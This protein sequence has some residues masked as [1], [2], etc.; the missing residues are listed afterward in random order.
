MA[1]LV[2][3]TAIVVGTTGLVFVGPSGAG[4][5]AMALRT[6]S[7]A[8][9]SG[10]FAALVSDD[11]VFLAPASGRLIATA[12]ETI[13]TM[14]ELRGS[15]IGHVETIDSV[16]LSFAIEPV[17]VDAHNRIPQENQRWTPSDGISLP[18]CFINRMAADPFDVLAA[19]ITGFPVSGSFQI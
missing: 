14:I 2:H 10:H 18:L 16:L 3:G 1:L 9:R 7:E 17:A 15:G 5:S 19:L 6:I 11:Q 13:R 8:R 12:P 4:K